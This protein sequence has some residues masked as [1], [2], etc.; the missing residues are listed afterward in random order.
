[1]TLGERITA[2]CEWGG[3][4]SADVAREVGVSRQAVSYW[5][6]GTN[7]PLPAVA[8]RLDAVLSR[9]EQ[10]PPRVEA[11]AGL[12]VRLKKARELRGLL[13]SELAKRIKVST[14]TVTR[15]EGTF[16]DNRVPGSKLLH[17]IAKVLKVDVNWLA[18]VGQTCPHCGGWISGEEKA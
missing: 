15:W 9:L 11:G 8:E 7:A 2:A 12:N 14:V 6:Q 1:M 13:Q 4:T 16:K 5:V 17:K 3:V 18:G 10:Q